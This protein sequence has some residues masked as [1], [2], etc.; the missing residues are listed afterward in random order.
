MS[1]Q[2]YTHCKRCGKPLKTVKSRLRGYGDECFKKKLG[3]K[4]E[5]KTYVSD[6]TGTENTNNEHTNALPKC[7]F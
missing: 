2:L 7:D 6:K 5:V 1:T 3:S 4:F